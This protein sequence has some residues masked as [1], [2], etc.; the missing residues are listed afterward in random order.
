MVAETSNVISTGTKFDA[1]INGVVLKKIIRVSKFWHPFC[2]IEDFEGQELQF[3]NCLFVTF[4][5]RSRFGTSPSLRT[6]S[7]V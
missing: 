7:L 2:R 3:I 1:R 5:F 4:G 6:M